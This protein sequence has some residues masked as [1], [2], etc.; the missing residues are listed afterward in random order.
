MFTLLMPSIQQYVDELASYGIPK[1]VAITKALNGD[2]SFVCPSVAA[3]VKEL[4]SIGF[5]EERAREVIVAK[6]FGQE[7]PP[8]GE[9][10][11]VKLEI[12]D[13]NFSSRAVSALESIHVRTVADLLARSPQEVL[14]AKNCGTKTLVEIRNFVLKTGLAT[15]EWKAE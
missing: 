1:E 9:K 2:V 15:D 3:F 5:S 8:P 7:V 6:L 11:L 13:I 14:D 4:E 12:R 10:P